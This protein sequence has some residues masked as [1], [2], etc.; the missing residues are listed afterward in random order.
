MKSMNMGKIVWTLP[1]DHFKLADCL[2]QVTTKSGSTVL[3]L[4]KHQYVSNQ[5]NVIKCTNQ[6]LQCPFLHNRT[7]DYDKCHSVL[8]YEQYPIWQGSNKN[9]MASPL[10]QMSS[11]KAR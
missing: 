1:R 7:S 2:T 10:N 4:H 11:V 6:F 8:F 5:N 9:I 3:L